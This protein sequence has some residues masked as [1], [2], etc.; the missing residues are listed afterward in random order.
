MSPGLRLLFYVAIGTIV[1]PVLTSLAMGTDLPSLWA[2]QG[3][4]LFVV[5]IVCGTRYPDRT[6]LHRQCH[7]HRRRR[8]ACRRPGRRTDPCRL[9]Q[10]SRL[11]RGTEF[12]R[13][14]GERAHPAMARADRRAARRRQWRRFAR[15]RDRLLQSGSSALRAAVRVSVRLGP[16]AQDDARS[17]LG[18]ALFPWPGLLR[19][20]D[21]VG[22]RAR[23]ALLSG[24]NSPCRPRCG[25]G[26]A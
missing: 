23:R 16:A 19:P 5:L 2:L 22:L 13:A 26:R 21:G 15:L 17:R 6:L 9:S 3:L 20:L 8:C 25:A 24:G 18:R 7:G 11:R 12:L 4:F 1:L 14:G 10:Q